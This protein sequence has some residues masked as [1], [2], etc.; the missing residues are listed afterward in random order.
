MH[1]IAVIDQ[2]GRTLDQFRAVLDAL[3]SG[4]IAGQLLHAVGA[5]P[6]G[7]RHV[8]VW[9]SR[10]HA[11]RFAARRL[12]PA[13]E[14]VYGLDAL[15]DVAVAAFDAEYLSVNGRCP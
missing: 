12:G 11:D 4:P 2:R 7:L 3:G 13:L 10:E 8:E 15:H 9:V 5:T 14:A 1:H 6:T